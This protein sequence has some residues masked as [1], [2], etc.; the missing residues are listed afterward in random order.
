MITKPQKYY[1]TREKINILK[2]ELERLKKTER[3]EVIERLKSAKEYG[4]LSENAEFFEAQDELSKVESKIFEIEDMLKNGI[5]IRKTVSNDKVGIGSTIEIK[6]DGHIFKYTIVG[7]FE[8]KPEEN[9]ISNESPLGKAFL[10]K[11]VRDVVAVKTP[12]GEVKYTIVK[13]E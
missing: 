4:D 10:N 2:E 13:I 9:L 8:A 12:Q 6:K 3:P 1:L 11:K 7:P 5:L